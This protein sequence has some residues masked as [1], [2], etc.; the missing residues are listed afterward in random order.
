VKKSSVPAT[1]VP[2][3]ADI[4]WVATA[5]TGT[6]ADTVTVPRVVTVTAHVMQLVE[7][8][9]I[10]NVPDPGEHTY[11]GVVASVAASTGQPAPKIERMLPLVLKKSRVPAASVPMLVAVKVDEVM[12]VTEYVTAL[13][14]Q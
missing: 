13:T 9:E 1:S 3:G 5:V 4:A 14:T 7:L 12:P 6:L 2:T 11:V 8:G 10:R